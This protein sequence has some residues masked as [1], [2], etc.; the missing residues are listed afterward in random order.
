MLD[1][2]LARRGALFRRCASVSPWHTTVPHTPNLPYPSPSGCDPGRTGSKI[3]LNRLQPRAAGRH[4][5]AH[6]RRHYLGFGWPSDAAGARFAA[7]VRPL[8][9]SIRSSPRN[10]H[11]SLL[12]TCSCASAGLSIGNDRRRLRLA[13]AG[14]CVGLNR[15]GRSQLERSRLEQ[16]WAESACVLYTCG[17]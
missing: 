8:H 9:L 14:G 3:A 6:P 5:R 16:G 10:S 12:R 2:V 4:R 7:R 11:T 15:P 13:V 1:V 17:G